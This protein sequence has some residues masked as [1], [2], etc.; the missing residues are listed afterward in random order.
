MKKLILVCISTLYLLSACNSKD[1]VGYYF[2]DSERDTL[3][4]NIISI[5]SER[6]AYATDS[7]KL[8]AKF[9][10]EFV[11]RL[12]RFHFV[13]LTK[14]SLGRYTYLISRPVAGRVDLRRGVL[15]TFTLKSNSL[16]IDDFE[17]VANTPHFDEETV[18]QRGGFLFKELVKKGNIIEY[19]TM[20]HYVEW[21]D[22]SLIYDKKKRSWVSTIG[23]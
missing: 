14:D 15:G 6:P 7:T 23:L 9:R 5:I 10:S 22:A 11:S 12:S 2:S 17:E 20:K 1:E 13:K 3:L 8:Q 18:K 16:Q 4:V 21:P 19:L